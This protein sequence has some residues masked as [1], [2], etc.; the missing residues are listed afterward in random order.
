MPVAQLS[1]LG[2]IRARSLF[3][4]GMILMA[5][6]SSS[7]EVVGI[8][9]SL[10]LLAPLVRAIHKWHIDIRKTSQPDSAATALQ[11]QISTVSQGSSRWS[12]MTWFER[13]YFIFKMLAHIVFTV[14]LLWFIWFAPSHPASLREVAFIG[15]LVAM[16]VMTSRFY[17]DT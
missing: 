10:V 17:E 2:V 8:I 15:L 6:A 16:I 11:S 12:R 14:T 13:G 1:T 9:A 3:N 5:I 7:S 4:S